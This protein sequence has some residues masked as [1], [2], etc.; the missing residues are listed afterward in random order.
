MLNKNTV[1]YLKVAILNEHKINLILFKQTFANKN[2]NE[3]IKKYFLGMIY[4]VKIFKTR[5]LKNL[6][7]NILFKK[8]FEHSVSDKVFIFAL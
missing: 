1:L 6:T 7:Q 5:K 4:S 8:I 2:R 3:I